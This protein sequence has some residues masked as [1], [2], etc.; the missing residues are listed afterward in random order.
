M[1]V[2]QLDPNCPRQL[3]LQHPTPRAIPPDG[4]CTF[5]F[6]SRR[7]HTRCGRD[8]SSDVCSSDL[9]RLV[10][11]GLATTG[12]AGVL[13]WASGQLAGLA[14]GH[15]WMHVSPADVAAI[16]WHLPH[17]WSDPAMAWPADVRPALPKCFLGVV[18]WPG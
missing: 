3:Q 11:Y 6:S 5:F 4:R 1:M 15:T 2:L 7:R 8:W 18:A 9:E 10:G 14:F 16:M 17:T 13:V 12:A